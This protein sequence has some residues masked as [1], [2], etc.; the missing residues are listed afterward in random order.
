MDVERDDAGNAETFINVAQHARRETFAALLFVLATVRIHRYNERDFC[1]SCLAYRIDGDKHGHDV[2][3]D[4]KNLLVCA[5]IERQHFVI[6][7]ILKDED[8]KS[9]RLNSS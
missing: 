1:S 6:F 8:R 2:V 9:T 4:R 7:Y 3:I 5:V